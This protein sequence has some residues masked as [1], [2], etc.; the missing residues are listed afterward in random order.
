MTYKDY[1]S[2]NYPDSICFTPTTPN[3]V[4]LTA[5]SFKNRTNYGFDEISTTL[6]K[7]VITL[8]SYPLSKT[9]NLSLSI[10]IVPGNMKI[11]KVIPLFESDDH[12]LYTNYRPVSIIPSLLFRNQLFTETENFEHKSIWF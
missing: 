3:E 1:L 6:M 12:Q 2:C 9:M 5:K 11:A 8:I 4:V 10:G 7:S